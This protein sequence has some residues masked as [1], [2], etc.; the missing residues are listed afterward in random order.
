VTRWTTLQTRFAQALA[1]PMAERS[2]FVQATMADDPA[3]G[4]ELQQLLDHDAAGASAVD[5]LVQDAIDSAAAAWAGGARQALI[6]L[7]LGPWRI[8]AHVADGGMGSVYRA[9]RADGQFEQLAA[10]KLLNPALI[11]PQAQDRLAQ[12][13]QILARLTHPH[14]ARLLDGGSTAEGLPWLAMEFV[15]GEP[16][17]SW[18]HSRAL[19]TTE[20]LRLFVQVCAAVDYAHRN[21]VVHRDLKPSNILVDAEGQPKL[22]DF[23]IAKLLASVDTAA[24]LTRSGESLL[25]PSHASPEQIQGGTITT[26]TDVYAL[27]VLLYELLTGLRPHASASSSAAA[28]ARAIVE[29]DPPRPSSALTQDQGTGT[30]SRRLAALHGRGERLTPERLA[31]ELQGDLDNI[32]LMAL[33]KEPERRYASAQALAADVER[34]LAK[35][36]VQAR[37]ATLAYR[38]VTFWR[39]HP[40]A[41]PAT[42]AAVVL[43][44]AAGLQFTWRLADERDRALAAEAQARRAA[45]FSASVLQSTSAEDAAERQVPV[46]DLLDRAV[47]RAATELRDAP[48]VRTPVNLALASALSS[49]GAYEAALKPLQQALADARARGTDGRRDQARALSQQGVALHD[50]GRLDESMQATQEALVLWQQVGTPAEQAAAVGDLAMAL[51]SLRRRT[52]AEPVFRD[53]IARLRAV[54]GGDHADLAFM[55][56]NLAWGLHAM[57]RLDEAAPLYEEALAMQVRLGEADAV[58]GQ[59]LNNLAGVYFDRGDLDRAGS[60]WAEVLA[61][62]ERVYGSGGHAAVARSQHLLALVALERGQLQQADQLTAS[63]LVT[64]VKLLGE[65]H[66]WTANT[67][68]GRAAVQLALGRLDEAERLYRR[69]LAVRTRVLPAGHGDLAGNHLGLAQVALRRGQPAV[70]EAA[71][72]KALAIIEGLASPDRVPDARVKLALGRSLALQ[73][74]RAEGLDLA[75]QGLQ[76]LREKAPPTHWRVQA[77][78]VALTLPPFVP[79]A[80]PAAAGA[81]AAVR[82]ALRSRLSDDAPTVRALD[83]QLALQAAASN[84][85]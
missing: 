41:M 21:L 79:M 69:A 58:R 50:L 70:A 17:D 45:A 61:I 81:A 15:D 54:H 5:G 65:Q 80:T 32:V 64:N 68:Q 31:R 30:S 78:E 53:A 16:I 3:L 77:A 6:G 20:R 35:L 47:Q 72:R 73:G 9:R 75:K 1:L 36:P 76:R 62:N 38:S 39:R 84:G 51:N 85:S 23:G 13:R 29:T 66:R 83:A 18:C 12:E 14:I 55:L 33:R 59:T 40:V 22:L 63:A 26:A 57:R 27:G 49:W 48:E 71:L 34:H 60:L 74:R 52:E 24:G 19:D 2:A 82:E 37:P 44:V 42:A 43:A 56:N 25:T 11:S 10:L 46:L 67:L 8:E 28:L 7:S 4:T